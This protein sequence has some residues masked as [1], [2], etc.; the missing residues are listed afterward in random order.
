MTVSVTAAC[1]T[2]TSKRTLEPK[3]LMFA[4]WFLSSFDWPKTKT[5]KQ[6][7]RNTI[8]SMEGRCLVFMKNLPTGKDADGQE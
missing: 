6:A 8:V 1:G 2:P 3:L 5:L 4:K 7:R